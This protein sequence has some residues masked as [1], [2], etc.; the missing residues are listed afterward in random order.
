M[1]VTDRL[2]LDTFL[3]YVGETANEERK[4]YTDL[5]IR[6]T[7]RVNSQIELSAVGN[8][9]LKKRRLEYYHDSLPIELSYV[10]RTAFVEARV[11]F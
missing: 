10:P 4:A 1:N 5:D 2:S 9:L 6:A 11:R 7:Y 8:N 3:H